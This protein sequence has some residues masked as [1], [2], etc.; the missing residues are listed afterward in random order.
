[1]KHTLPENIVKDLNLTQISE[2]VYLMPPEGDVLYEINVAP[3]HC[4][5]FE[6]TSCDKYV[7]SWGTYSMLFL[8]IERM[9]IIKNWA[10]LDRER[11]KRK[12]T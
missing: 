2:F 3:N 10:K 4:N 12:N 11:F 1:M 6:F 7:I 5:T 9:P 8:T